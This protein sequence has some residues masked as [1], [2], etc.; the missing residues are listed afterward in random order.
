MYRDPQA[1]RQAIETA[2]K[3]TGWSETLQGLRAAPER[4]GELQ[5]HRLGRLGFDAGARERAV[6]AVPELA[7]T[8]AN[9]FAAQGAV[10]Q[11]EHQVSEL[12]RTRDTARVDAQTLGERLRGM[13]SQ[14]ELLKRAGHLAHELGRLAPAE[15]QRLEQALTQPHRA[16]LG[17]AKA[18]AKE[19]VLGHE[20]DRGMER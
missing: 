12:T 18:L 9:H 6:A 10:R 8:A 17:K 20:P 15:L 1:A 13:P 5:G 14:S 11:G 2:A 7:R 3:R 4:F 19:A 16:L